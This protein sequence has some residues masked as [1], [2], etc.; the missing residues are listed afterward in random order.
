MSDVMN[1]EQAKRVF[2]WWTYV[3]QSN[4][5][6]WSLDGWNE[7]SLKIKAMLRADKM[8]NIHFSKIRGRE[9]G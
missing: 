6:L 9:Q 2:A 4:P 8:G 3:V 1:L 7:S 5:Q